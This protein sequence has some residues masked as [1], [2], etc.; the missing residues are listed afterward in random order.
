MRWCLFD[1]VNKEL[2]EEVVEKY[3]LTE[4]DLHSI[5]QKTIELKQEICGARNAEVE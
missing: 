4:E 2:L 5:R 1:E 3:N